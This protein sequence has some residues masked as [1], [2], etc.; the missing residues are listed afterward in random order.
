[1]LRA[2]LNTFSKGFSRTLEVIDLFLW[3]WFGRLL[4]APSPW[5]LAAIILKLLFSRSVESSF[6][7]PMDSSVP[8]RLLCQGDFPGKNTGV[9]C[10]FPLQGI[11]PTQ[12]SN[13]HLLHWQAGSL[14]LSHLGSTCKPLQR[15]VFKIKIQVSLGLENSLNRG[16]WWATVH[17]VTES[18]TRLSN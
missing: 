7:Q 16:D 13:P 5:S 18:R 12:G 3:C 9:G 6:L 4:S 2:V 17:G 11:F 14:P 15:K 8:A 10:H 1:M